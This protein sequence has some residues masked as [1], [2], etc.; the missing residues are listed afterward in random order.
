MIEFSRKNYT[1]ILFCGG[2]FLSLKY[3]ICTDG[4]YNRHVRQILWHCSRK[5]TTFYQIPQAFSMWGCADLGP[6]AVVLPKQDS[7]PFQH[8]TRMKTNG[9]STHT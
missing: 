4:F 8:F 1:L 3:V 9:L 5:L 7:H 6:L 2:C